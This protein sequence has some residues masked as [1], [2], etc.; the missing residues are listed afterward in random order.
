MKNPVAH[1]VFAL[2]VITPIVLFLV[3]WGEGLN[4]FVAAAIS[5]VAGW[6]LGVA[7]ALTAFDH[8]NGDRRNIAIATRY[9]WACPTVLVLGSWIARHFA[10][11][12]AV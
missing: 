12:Y 8:R 10:A 3:L 11:Q 6:I 4:R 9:G 7:W 2:A 1:V 5:V